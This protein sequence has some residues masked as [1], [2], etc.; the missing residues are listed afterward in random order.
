MICFYVFMILAFNPIASTLVKN[1]E[2]IKGKYEKK[3]DNFQRLY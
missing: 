3:Q 2:S 1:Y